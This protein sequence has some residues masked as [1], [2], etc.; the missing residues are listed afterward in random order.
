M[1]PAELFYSHVQSQPVDKTLGLMSRNIYDDDESMQGMKLSEKPKVW[2]DYTCLR[3]CRNDFKAAAVIALIKEIGL[4]LT[5]LDEEANYLKRSFCML[6][7]F[8]TVAG[9]AKLLCIPTEQG[10]SKWTQNLDDWVL[11]VDSAAAQTRDA[12]DK[13]KIDEYI[14]STVGFTRLNDIVAQELYKGC[15]AFRETFNDFDD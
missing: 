3:Q 13:V 14:Q 10:P 11:E 5:E 8:G 4:T 9:N 7:L 12:K 6:E 2:L 1:G 15:V